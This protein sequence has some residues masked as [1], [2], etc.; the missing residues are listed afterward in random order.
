M[1]LRNLSWLFW[2]KYF[3]FS[4]YFWRRFN[5]RCKSRSLASSSFTWSKYSEIFGYLN[6]ISR[7]FINNI[8]IWNILKPIICGYSSSLVNI[9]RI[10]LDSMWIIIIWFDK[11]SWSSISWNNSGVQ[12][13]LSWLN[14]HLFFNW[15]VRIY[16]P[17][18]IFSNKFI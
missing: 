7:F 12:V 2:V 14:I 18:V 11:C 3:K 9:F 8:L 16:Y 6:Y 5:L 15:S 17:H 13:S 10:C 4:Y 1:R